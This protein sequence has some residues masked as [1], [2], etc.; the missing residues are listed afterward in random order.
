MSK[1]SKHS[2]HINIHMIL[3]TLIVIIFG[4]S[5]F[6]LYQWNKGE[7]IEID[8]EADT[9]QFDVEALDSIMPLPL[10]K[11]EGHTYD[12]ELSILFLGN[13]MVAALPDKEESVPNQVAAMTGATV[14][15]CGFT[16]CTL[17]A[18]NLN[19]IEKNCPSDAFSLPYLVD[20]ICTGDFSLQN[21]IVE[22]H[23]EESKISQNALSIM[24][25]IDYNSIDVICIAYDATDYLEQRGV[26]NPDDPHEICT[27]TGALRT[28]IEKLQAT[29]PFIRIIVMSPTYVSVLT[30]DGFE[31]ESGTF[32]FGHGVLSHYLLK[33][34]DV[35][36]ELA[37]SVVDNFYGTINQDNYTEYLYEGEQFLN[38]AGKTKIAERF[39]YALEKY[40]TH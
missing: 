36:T 20:S 34:I 38:S 28:S 31:I 23:R 10:S 1:N 16:E 29:Y 2:F 14:Y 13:E 8:P 15:N 4:I 5:A 17:T 32:N 27:Y 30:E 9:S 19:F 18:K 21:S 22:K 11:Q 35:C 39:V 12:D 7:R 6:R 3:I 26:E 37:V 24:Q 33:E 40:T 25:S